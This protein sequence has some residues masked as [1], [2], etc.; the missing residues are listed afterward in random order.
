MCDGGT[1]QMLSGS[2]QPAI[3]TDDSHSG[4]DFHLLVH[5]SHRGKSLRHSCRGLTPYSHAALQP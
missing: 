1:L 3:K 5:F 4:A 2:R